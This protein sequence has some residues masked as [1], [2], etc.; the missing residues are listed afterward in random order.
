[1]KIKVLGTG[2]T[3]FGELWDKSLFD[4]AQEAALEAI[5]DSHLAVNQIEAVF[6]ANMLSGKLS[7]QDHLGAVVASN[8]GLSG[9]SFRI[10]AACASGGLAVHLAI[11][12]LLSG[13]Y[14]KVLV[15]GVEKMTD[16][17]A[18][19]ITSALMGAGSQTERLAGLTFPGLYALMAKAHM[20]KYGTTKNE[21]AQVAVKNHYHASLND[22]AQFPYEV[23][24]EKVLESSCIC[25]PFTLFDASPVSDGA[26]ALVLSADDEPGSLP[27]GRQVFISGSA[28]A[29]D[30][31]DLANRKSLTEITATQTASQKA[32]KQA[33]VEIKDIKVAEVHDCFTIAEILAMEDLGFCQKG[34]GGRFIAKGTTKLGGKLPVNT[35]GGLKACGHPVGATGV[36]QIVEITNQLRG[37]LGKRQVKGANVGLTQNVGGT[38]ATVVVHVL[39]N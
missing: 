15:V 13:T 34:E 39:Q 23:T 16:S 32:L 27:A 18:S 1:M 3:K 17:P 29:T 30:T 20:Q 25:T 5:G 26:G 19:E 14:K 22:K 28:V 7:G 36:K 10:E 31:I 6:V 38:G 12:S 21:L 4:L 11:Q 24:E 8:L 2:L 35:S 37:N 9:A 33:G